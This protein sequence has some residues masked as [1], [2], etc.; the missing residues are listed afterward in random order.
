MLLGRQAFWQA[1]QRDRAWADMTCEHESQGKKTL[2]T[3][4]ECVCVCVC[5]YVCV[6]VPFSLSLIVASCHSTRW[7]FLAQ[8]VESRERERERESL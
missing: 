7:C 2:H 3:L 8:V 4:Q 1:A 5:V 6:C